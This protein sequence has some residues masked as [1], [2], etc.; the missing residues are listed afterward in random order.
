MTDTVP[1]QATSSVAPKLIPGWPEVLSGTAGY[2]LALSGVV[3]LLPLIEDQATAG[4]LGLLASG[5][6]GLVALV[7]A[8]LVRRPGWRVFGFRRARPRHVVLGAGLGLAAYI[9][10]VVVSLAYLALA[11]DISNVQTSYQAAAASSPW[12]LVLALVGGALATPLG[13]E[14]F[15]RGVVANTL[16]RRTRVW[17]AVVISAAIFAVAHGI[18]PV[19]PIAFIVGVFTGLLFHWSKSVWPGVVLHGVNNA[20]ALLVPL[21]LGAIAP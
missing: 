18:N 6:I 14:A 20:T 10:G 4:V 15:F 13:E 2:A 5:F 9:L 12:S 17:V 19:L 21:V 11:G 1:T 16:L 3:F 7:A 8:F